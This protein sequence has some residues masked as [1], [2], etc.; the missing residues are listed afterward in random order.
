[1]RI[2]KNSHICTLIRQSLIFLKLNCCTKWACNSWFGQSVAEKI[3]RELVEHLK[4][5]SQRQTQ[6]QS[7]KNIIP[8]SLL[9]IHSDWSC[10][11]Y[12]ISSWTFSYSFALT[13]TLSPTLI[14]EIM[15]GTSGLS[16]YHCLT[17]LHLFFGDICRVFTCSNIWWH[18][19]TLPS[20]SIQFEYFLC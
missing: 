2:R 12:G 18:L 5:D 4:L 10:T 7:N 3:K 9:T 8:I 11:N 17:M 14:F 16:T 20:V 15:P 1:M 6:Y 13:M 19:C